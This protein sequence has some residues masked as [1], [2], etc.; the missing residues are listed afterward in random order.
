M[1]YHLGTDVL[2]S[3]AFSKESAC[4]KKSTREAYVPLAQRLGSVRSDFAKMQLPSDSVSEEMKF[5]AEIL[6][7]Q[8]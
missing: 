6:A 1:D 5:Q 4:V 7:P 8:H 3:T 2:N